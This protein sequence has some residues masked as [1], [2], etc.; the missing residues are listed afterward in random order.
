MNCTSAVKVVPGKG[1]D[2]GGHSDEAKLGEQLRLDGSEGGLLQVEDHGRPGPERH[3]ELHAE[4]GGDAQQGCQ[5]QVLHTRKQEN[6]KE[7]GKSILSSSTSKGK[8]TWLS[9]VIWSLILKKKY[10][11]K[12]VLKIVLRFNFDSVTCASANYSFSPIFLV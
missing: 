5:C 8:A 1:D 9:Y 3:P 2:G 11:L 6:E 7:T 4:L 10:F 12:I